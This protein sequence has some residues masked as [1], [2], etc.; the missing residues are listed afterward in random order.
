MIAQGRREKKVA[1]SLKLGLDSFPW[2]SHPEEW[3]RSSSGEAVPRPSVPQKM[4][5]LKE[6][7]GVSIVT[8]GVCGTKAML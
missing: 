8:S 1:Q 2:R 3:L 4:L 5:G 6:S 7:H